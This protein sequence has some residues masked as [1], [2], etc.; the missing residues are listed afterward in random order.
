MVFFSRI[1]REFCLFC[2]TFSLIYKQSAAYRFAVCCLSLWHLLRRGY[3][4]DRCED[5]RRC[6][7]IKNLNHRFCKV[8][9]G[10]VFV[11]L[12]HLVYFCKIN[13]EPVSFTL[14]AVFGRESFPGFPDRVGWL[15]VL[16]LGW[17]WRIVLW[18]TLKT[19]LIQCEQFVDSKPMPNL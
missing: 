13:K 2:P 19:G 11:F 17:Q 5:R 7:P 18:E 15:R 6:C 4:D 9:T 8:I 14:G 3:G 16:H 1:F 10:R 12:V